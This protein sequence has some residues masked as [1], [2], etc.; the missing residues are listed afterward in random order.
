MFLYFFEINDL[1]LYEDDNVDDNCTP[2]RSTNVS[3]VPLVPPSLWGLP[4]KEGRK[5]RAEL[6]GNDERLTINGN[7]V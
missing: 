4:L 6:R 2:T 1:R 5:D 7:A 3:L